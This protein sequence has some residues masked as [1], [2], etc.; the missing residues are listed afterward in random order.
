MTSNFYNRSTNSGIQQVSMAILACLPLLA[1]YAIPFPVSLGYAFVL[2]L[3]AYSIVLARL[4]INVLPIAFWFVFAYIAIIWIY[5]NNFQIWSLFPPGGWQF[6]IF[7]MALIWGVINFRRDLLIKYMRWIV[8]ISA[9]LFWVQF[10]LKISTGSSM[11]CFVPNLTG[12]FSYEGMTYSELV[13]HQLSGERPCSIFMEP[14]YMAHYLVSYIALVWF[15]NDSKDKLLNKETLF[16]ILTLLALRSGSGMIDLVALCLIKIFSIFWN[17]G[18]TKRV[19]LV[20]LSIPI[21]ACSIHLYIQTDAGQNMLSRSEE[22]STEG[23]S[24]YTRVVGGFMMFDQLDFNERLFGIADA[25]ERF[26]IERRDGSVVFFAN[27]FQ[28]ILLSFGYIGTFLYLIFYIALFRKVNLSSRV[29]LIILLLMSLLESNYLNPFMM[30]LTIIPCAE[31]YQT[32][33]KPSE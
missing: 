33:I 22:F 12:A 8:W 32:N 27:G 2:F 23:T 9:T 25:R 18:N 26:G 3:S 10:I 24:G 20:F 19:A 14:S 7:V 30:L 4:R 28:T 17:T 5:R 21:I 13:A 15:S 1:W 6:F 31:Y 29:C 11:F 16:I